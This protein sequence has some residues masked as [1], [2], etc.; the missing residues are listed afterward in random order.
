MTLEEKQIIEDYFQDCEYIIGQDEIGGLL[1]KINQLLKTRQEKMVENL[2]KSKIDKDD[3]LFNNLPNERYFNR[4]FNQGI[5]K[6]IE[7]INL[8]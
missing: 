1:D 3:K 6:A 8:N 5:D 7:I 4:G 2:E